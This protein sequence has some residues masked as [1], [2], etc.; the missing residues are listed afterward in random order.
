MAEGGRSSRGRSRKRKG[1]RGKAVFAAVLKVILVLLI[2]A[3]LLFSST[4]FLIHLSEP[5]RQAGNSYAAFSLKKN[6]NIIPKT[7]ILLLRLEFT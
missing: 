6:N 2:A 4:L 1:T 3:G 5:P 7:F